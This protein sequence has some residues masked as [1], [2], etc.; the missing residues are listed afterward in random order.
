MWRG[1]YVLRNTKLLMK[2]QINQTHQEIYAE[3]LCKL[4]PYGVWW[5]YTHISCIIM[6]TYMYSEHLVLPTLLKGNWRKLISMNFF[7]RSA[8]KVKYRWHFND[9]WLSFHPINKYWNLNFRQFF[10][11]QCICYSQKLS[12][13]GRK[14]G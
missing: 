14:Q 13:A 2:I 11:F 10:F 12:L 1:I 4:F 8:V 7:L 3:I 6:Y 9:I 5:I